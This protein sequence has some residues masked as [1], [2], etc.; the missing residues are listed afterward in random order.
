ML[1]TVFGFQVIVEL[2]LVIRK[3]AIYFTQMEDTWPT[4]T[5]R[6]SKVST[7]LVAIATRS[8]GVAYLPF[9]DRKDLPEKT[10]PA[11]NRLLV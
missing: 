4:R 3:F 10:T 5:E 7:S 1:Q 11:F 9:V 6:L 8:S 2:V